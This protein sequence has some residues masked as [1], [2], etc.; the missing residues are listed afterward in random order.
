[1][2]FNALQ[3]SAFIRVGKS[4]KPQSP[5]LAEILA[6]IQSCHLGPSP[7]HQFVPSFQPG[8]QPTR[9]T[10]QPVMSED[11]RGLPEPSPQGWVSAALGRVAAHAALPGAPMVAGRE[12]FESPTTK[13]SAQGRVRTSASHF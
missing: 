5:S 7:A 1:M 13:L 12:D 4:G 3:E 10:A 2:Q 6:E 11:A 9:V 8:G